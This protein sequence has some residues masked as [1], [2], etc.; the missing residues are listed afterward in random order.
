MNHRMNIP[1]SR[2][3]H[4]FP[5][6]LIRVLATSILLGGTSPAE[7]HD[8]S[9]GDRENIY[10]YL[11]RVQV[12]TDPD[13]FASSNFDHALHLAQGMGLLDLSN[14][15]PADFANHLQHV[16]RSEKRFYKQAPLKPEEV[17]KWLLPL[18]IRY[19]IRTSGAWMPPLSEKFSAIVADADSAGTAAGKI[20]D[21]MSDN[22]EVTGNR[23]SNPL[24]SRGD[25]DPLTVIKGGRGTEVDIAVCAVASLRSVGI[26]SRIVW[27]PALRGGNGGKLWME[28]LTE[29]R[30]W[31]PWVPSFGGKK[32]HKSEL[33]RLFGQDIAAVMAEPESPCDITGSYVDT[34][35]VTFDAT[36]GNVGIT[37]LVTGSTEL[38]PVF[39]NDAEPGGVRDTY[40]IGRGAFLV[41]ASF[42]NRRF[43]LLP[44]DGSMVSDHVRIQAR[45]GSLVLIK[46]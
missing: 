46:N 20:L 44:I 37:L 9:A 33:R 7:Y 17:K 1:H 22:L 16:S 4:L 13:T 35:R 30:T 24:P 11:D 5:N 34:M 38:L 8:A 10:R 29:S 27:T 19:E 2:A 42:S 3:R 25:L 41:A 40:T 31:E 12:E 23:P 32:D 36:D 28:Y 21:W 18:R 26:A 39:G 43:A 6:I 15:R 45:D 14:V